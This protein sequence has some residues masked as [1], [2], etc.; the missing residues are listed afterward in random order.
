[1]GDSLDSPVITARGLAEYG[2]WTGNA[3]ESLGWL[4]R[5]YALSPLGEDYQV[6]ASGIYDKVRNDPRFKAGLQ[7]ARTQIYDR[8]QRARLGGRLK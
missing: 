5:A 7:R 6:I 2:A 4:E 3:E 8:V 1:V